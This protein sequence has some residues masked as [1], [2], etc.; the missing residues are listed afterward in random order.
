MSKESPRIFKTDN[1]K[2][3]SGTLTDETGVVLNR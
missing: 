3:V 2:L 1:A